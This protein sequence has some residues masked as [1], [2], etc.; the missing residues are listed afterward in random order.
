M[1]SFRMSLII[2]LQLYLI[3]SEYLS[4][5]CLDTVWQL[6][7]PSISN[8]QA[9]RGKQSL[10]VS[11]LVN[12]SGIVGEINEIQISRTES[13]IIIYNKNVSAPSADSHE[14]T[15]TWT[16]DLPLECVDHS[17]RIRYFYNQT[18]PSPWSKWVTNCGCEAKDKTRM[19][20]F[21]RVLREGTSAMFCCVPPRGVNITSI[22]FKKSQY[23][24]ISIGARVKAISVENLTIPTTDI[25][26]LLLSCGDTTGEEYSVWNYVSFPAQ[27]PRNLSCAT[28]QLTTVTCTWD[29][30]R[31][32]HPHDHNNQTRTLHIENSDQAPV[33]CEPSSCTFAAIPNL[34]Q[35]NIRV[36][37]K[38]QL[39][40]ETESHS[41]N[42][43]DRV[44]PVAEWD[45]VSPGVADTTVSWIIQGNLT[46]LNLICQVSVDPGSTTE[47]NCNSASGRCKFKLEDLLPNTL[48]S[49]KVR[50]S[51]NGRLWG[52]WTHALPFKTCP[53]VTLNLWRRL[54]QTSEIYSRQVTLLW[55][56]NAPGSATTET[57]QR[58][59]VQWT[60]DGQNR[61]ERKD[62]AQTQAEVLIG[63][64]QC[65][66]T[67]QAVLHTCPPINA[68]ITIPKLD[69]RENL[70]VERRLSSSPAGGFNLS[71]PE[72]NTATCAYTV[73]WCNQGN[74]VPC[75][76]RWIKMQKGNH[77]LLLPATGRRYTFNIYGCTENGHRLL[78]V[79][80]G[81]SQELQAV[82]QPSVVK[83][84][85]STPSS[86]TLE[87]H[88][89]EDDPAHPAFITGY[90]V[91]VQEV[92]SNTRPGHIANMLVEDPRKKSVIIEDLK[93]G[94]EYRFSVSALTK[95][96]PGIPGMIPFRTRTNY[97]AHL[98][99]ILTPILLLL[100]CTI[101]LW[102][103]RKMLKRGLKDIFVYP[104]G[105]NI[106]SFEIDGF[107]HEAGERVQSHKVEECISCD[108]EILNTRPLLTEAT[109]LRD[110]E[111]LNT[112]CSPGSQS[113]P[114]SLSEPHKGYC[115]QSAELLSE[116]PAPQQITC[117]TNKSYFHTT[118][119]D[120]SEPQEV[121]NSEIKSTSEPS[122]CL[123]ESCSVVSGYISNDTS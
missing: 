107:L 14:H 27:K 8:L 91:T 81:Y 68:H 35:Y 45:R 117:I 59:T 37:V 87:W 25:N 23:P 51:V 50:C 29:P 62:G 82:H 110:P 48:Y 84:V 121:T 72:L 79:Q 55:T 44:V 33:N 2:L 9:N 47:L 116:R 104:A 4:G 85:Q 111:P 95:V 19:F 96:G 92:G 80:T 114:S 10:V 41:F 118:V 12:H 36:V 101:L 123:Q 75:T 11:W 53:F 63:P 16:S 98:A 24:L 38:D 40:E 100:G 3:F 54:K 78:E 120:F 83:P 58:Y 115:P 1:K 122:D 7:V 46:G 60:Q 105:M 21:Q 119:E 49:T 18:A 34:E 71:W 32:R 103:Q 108:I 15:W 69:D 93:Q 106:K 99:K 20:P 28:S 90:L 13:H 67:V 76:L 112:L 77:T 88:Y 52:K 102:P 17:V 61:T 31:Y 70:Q 66:F 97:S 73:E 30:G 65:D 57:V 5:C 43:S 74:A 113:S 22:A 6:P 42:I 94:H 86:V 89:N 109:T 56:L 26:A 64:G 39:G